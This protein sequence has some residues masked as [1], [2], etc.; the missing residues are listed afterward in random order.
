[1]Q[2][3][4]EGNECSDKMH[5]KDHIPSSLV[6]NGLAN[7]K[8]MDKDLSNTAG[9]PRKLGLPSHDQLEITKGSTEDL[10][11]SQML[12]KPNGTTDKEMQGVK[13]EP[14]RELPKKVLEVNRQKLRLIKMLSR[15]PEMK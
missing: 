10:T 13:S 12:G 4:D 2:A 6:V 3:K 1:L 15:Q 11:H 5:S 14:K 8:S 7:A 9:N